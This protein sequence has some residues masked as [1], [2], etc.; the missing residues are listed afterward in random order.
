M[1]LG[2]AKTANANHGTT[3]TTA[4]LCVSDCVTDGVRFA[5]PQAPEWKHIGN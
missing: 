4:K 3:R 5:I 2:A 1:R